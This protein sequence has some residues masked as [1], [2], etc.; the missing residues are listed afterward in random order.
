M[1]SYGEM[2]ISMPMT[3]EALL[4]IEEAARLLRVSVD[5]VRRMIK[6][7]QLDGSKVR[8]QWRIRKAS[9]DKYL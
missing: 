1:Q 7:K 4:T 5:T 8:G 2:E 9:V 3:Q 6:D